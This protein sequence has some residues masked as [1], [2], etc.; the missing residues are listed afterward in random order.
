M[1]PTVGRNPSTVGKDRTAIA[2][3]RRYK[4]FYRPL[5]GMFTVGAF[6]RV[7]TSLVTSLGVQSD[8]EFM[9]R[10][11]TI[12]FDGDSTRPTERFGGYDAKSSNTWVSKPCRT[13]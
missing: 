13:N 1:I 10:A 12:E 2:D 4:P 9:P 8:E 11:D 7:S 5:F 3:M 6:G